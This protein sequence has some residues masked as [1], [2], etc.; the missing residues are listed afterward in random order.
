M[1][2]TQPLRRQHLDDG[3]KPAPGLDR[4]P[5]HAA[6]AARAGHTSRPPTRSTPHVCPHLST[7]STPYARS[8]HVTSRPLIPTHTVHACPRK[9]HLTPVH[10]H[11]RRPRHVASRPSTPTH[12][13]HTLPGRLH[14]PTPS[15]P[16]TPRARPCSPMPSTL[17]TPLHAASARRSDSCPWEAAG[18]CA[19]CAGL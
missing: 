6:R 5:A 16:S 7:P 17:S 10:E 2:G 12:A 18:P 8:C 14:L 11:P 15:T 9:V 4:N 13:G 19:S 1:P 3:T